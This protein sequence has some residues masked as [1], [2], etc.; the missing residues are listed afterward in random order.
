LKAAALIL[1]G[2]LAA[3]PAAAQ[4]L[5]LSGEAGQHASLTAA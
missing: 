2:V 3:G 1:A 5:S 4:T